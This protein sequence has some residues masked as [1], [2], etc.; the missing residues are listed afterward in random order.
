MHGTAETISFPWPTPPEPGQ[1]VDLAPGLKWLRLALPFQ[2]NHV[3]IYMLADNG[4]WAIVDT[5]IGTDSTKAAWEAVCFRDRS[6][7]RRSRA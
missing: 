6:P 2:L 3:N 1:V 4:G 7:E 5:G